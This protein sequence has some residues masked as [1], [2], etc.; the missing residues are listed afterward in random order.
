M[1]IQIQGNGGVVAEVDGATFR[2]LRITFR[3]TDYGSL[4]TYRLA[5]QSGL[6]AAGLAAN[7]EIF[8]YRWG[9]AT[10]LCVVEKLMFDGLGSVTAF[11]AGVINLR[12]IIARS[13]TANGTGG[14]AATLTGNNQ[15]LRTNMATTLT[16]DAR[17]ASTAALGAG[18]KTL[19]AQSIGAAVG[20]ITA[21][22]GAGLPP[23]PF[24]DVQGIGMPA[25]YAQNEGHA[26]LATVPATGT[27]TFGITQ[28][29]LEVTA[30]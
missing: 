29:W 3:P 25:V 6:M 21:T 30:Y 11:A 17:C 5:M 9:D 28:H 1:A 24:I 12:A 18:T 8:Q 4:G 16:T 19:D 26:I 20:G 10:R 15:K 14:T 23:Q 22:A 27:W 7:A 2:A 13:W